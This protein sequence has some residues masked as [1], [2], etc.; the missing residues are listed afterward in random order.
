MVERVR[1]V[2]KRDRKQ[3]QHQPEDEVLQQQSKRR[4]VKGSELQRR[5]P[6]STSPALSIPDTES[7]GQHEKAIATELTKSKPRETV[8]L[9]LIKSTY[10]S[11][12]MFIMNEAVSVDSHTSEV[13]C[14]FFLYSCKWI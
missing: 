8:L 7:L 13:P 1:N 4:A 9:P 3:H 10:L 5:Y 2:I 6:V 11:H 12:R 14:P